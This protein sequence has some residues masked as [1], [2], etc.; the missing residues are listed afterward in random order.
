MRMVL[1][2][3][4]DLKNITELEPRKGTDDPNFAYD[5]KVLII[6]RDFQEGGAPIFLLTSQVGG[7]GLTLTKADHVIVVNPAWNPRETN[8]IAYGL[9]KLRTT[10]DYEDVLY[11]NF[12]D[13]MK[14]MV[15]EDA[16]GKI[17]FSV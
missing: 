15:Q 14:N 1:M 9:S 17:Y 13:D 11:V 6:Y 2:I 12:S 5:F 3:S 4:V 10:E 7:L 8:S 16:K